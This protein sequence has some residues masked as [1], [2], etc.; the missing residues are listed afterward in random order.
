MTQVSRY[1]SYREGTV[2]LRPYKSPK[3]C[4][5][6]YMFISVYQSVNPSLPSVYCVFVNES[7]FPSTCPP[8]FEA[9][10]STKKSIFP[11]FY[12]PPPPPSP[13][14][15]LQSYLPI[16]CESLFICSIQTIVIVFIMYFTI[17]LQTMNLWLCPS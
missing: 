10:P 14:T 4:L 2:S 6:V 5:P 12:P 8:T 3:L 1:V 15:H 13:W 7:I 11:L 17:F 16:V 9:T